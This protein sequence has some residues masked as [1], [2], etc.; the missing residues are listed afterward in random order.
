MSDK[1]QEHTPVRAPLEFDGYSIYKIDD[2]EGDTIGLFTSDDLD[3]RLRKS[4]L[5]ATG[6]ALVD[7]YNNHDALKT[8][9]DELLEALEYL[10]QVGGHIEITQ[11]L[12][13]ETIF[14]TQFDRARAAILKAKSKGQ[15]Q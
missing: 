11:G 5:Q 12:R 1:K 13:I 7:R 6:Q 15:H 9:R 14:K 4:N 8:Q 3:E 10:M 2:T